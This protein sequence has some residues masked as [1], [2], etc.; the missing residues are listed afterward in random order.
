[1]TKTTR[2]EGSFRDYFYDGRNRLTSAAGGAGG[3]VSAGFVWRVGALA[4]CGVVEALAD[5]SFFMRL[6]KHLSVAL[7][8]AVVSIHG[9]AAADLAEQV[10]KLR[11]PK[12][13]KVSI[14]AENVPNARGMALGAKG[15]LF[16]G[17]RDV[18]TVHAVVDSDGDQKADKVLQIIGPG[19]VL[20]DGAK[21]DMPHGVAFR[22]G[23]LYVSSVSRI[24]RF[25]DIEAHLE[26]PPTPVVLPVK[27]SE[28]AQH[29][30]KYIAFGPDGK[31]YVPQGAWC[32]AC[33]FPD[34]LFGSI[35]RMNADGTGLEV[36]AKGV[37]NTIGFDFHPE[38]G[39]LW[40]TENGD[41]RLG[42]NLPGDE[43]NRLSAPGQHF[44]FPYVHQGDL[45]DPY[46]GKG[47][48]VEDYV[49][50]A[51]VLGPHVAALGMR[52]YTGK[53]FPKEY[54]DQIFIAEHG[55]GGAREKIGYRV[56]LVRLDGNKAVSYEV[57]AEGWVQEGKAWG[58]PTDVLVM[59]DG[60]LLVADDRA[61]AIYRISYKK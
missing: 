51:Q 44:G 19:V 21:F 48:K 55:S 46:F 52:F 7:V 22:D 25:D 56:M 49:A 59:P 8:A 37:R 3:V 6:I 29:G 47:K 45:L 31:L 40:F 28:T 30:W 20:A 18:D 12:G 43:L 17:T 10:S 32:N 4:F 57:F 16:V 36:I 54:R 58:R 5:R 15:T 27:F 26:S 50:P 53:M 9:L 13:F 23:A 42:E 14:Y 41:D 33:D 34:E 11:V 35:T 61:N 24:I 60:A 2:L 38:T 1:M 39:E